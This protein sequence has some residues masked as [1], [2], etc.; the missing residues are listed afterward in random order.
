MCT[1][2]VDTLF[3]CDCHICV[4]SFVLNL[5]LFD[6][7]VIKCDVFWTTYGLLP[8]VEIISNGPANR[9]TFPS[10]K[11]MEGNTFSNGNVV[12]RQTS[13]YL[14]RSKITVVLTK[15]LMCFLHNLIVDIQVTSGLS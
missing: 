8:V 14:T 5:N 3:L 4:K 7:D 11:F 15:S 2:F 1:S 9:D 12:S 13:R 6:K 10:L